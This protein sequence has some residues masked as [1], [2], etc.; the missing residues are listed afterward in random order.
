MLLRIWHGTAA[1]VALYAAPQPAP[2]WLTA[3]ERE[4]VTT[5]ASVIEGDA[6]YFEKCQEP[7]HAKYCWRRAKVFRDLLARSTPPEVV[8]PECVFDEF[9]GCSAVHAWNICAA[10]F[11]KALAAAGVAVKE[12]GK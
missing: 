8:H 5:M 1:V 12:A 7:D 10:D 6:A 9:S 3:E 4:A 11:R 2:G